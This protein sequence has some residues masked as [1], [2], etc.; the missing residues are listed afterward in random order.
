MIKK[1]S[2][3]LASLVLAAALPLASNAADLSNGLKGL[4][5]GISKAK[6]M[7][8]LRD[9]YGSDGSHCVA[10]KDTSRV[11]EEMS[12][13]AGIGNSTYSGKEL[14]FS[15][16]L[17]VEGRLKQVRLNFSAA[18]TPQ[19]QY[20]KLAELQTSL[21]KVMGKPEVINDRSYVWLDNKLDAGLLVLMGKTPNGISIPVIIYSD[22]QILKK[23]NAS[24]RTT[25]FKKMDM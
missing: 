20:E 4:I 22:N 3:L 13:F 8:I 18:D 10:N 2:G 5:I 12:T 1:I 11:Y 23:E 19:K 6:T 14:S 16:V 25:D 24:V 15:S 21:A 17:F 9:N 7:E